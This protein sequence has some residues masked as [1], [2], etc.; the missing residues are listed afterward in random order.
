MVTIG[1]HKT[2]PPSPPIT[3]Y[4]ST[5]AE[6]PGV[7]TEIS[8]LLG[9]EFVGKVDRP[10]NSNGTTNVTLTRTITP[11]PLLSESYYGANTSGR[12]LRHSGFAASSFVVTPNPSPGH[13][14]SALAL[15]SS[16]QSSQS[17]SDDEDEPAD[18]VH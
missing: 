12:S 3:T 7:I 15:N 17:Q 6:K 14:N 1:K 16:S 8:N 2:L 11:N 4:P 13:G 9:V 5:S 18:E 10:E